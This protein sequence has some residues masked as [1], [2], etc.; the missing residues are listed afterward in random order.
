MIDIEMIKSGLL[1]KRNV[2]RNNDK[3]MK[4][5]QLLRWIVQMN[6]YQ[7]NNVIF[8]QKV[9]ITSVLHFYIRQIR[10]MTVANVSFQDLIT[11]GI[12]NFYFQRKEIAFCKY[13]Y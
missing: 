8:V 5:H 10:F 3:I 9:I 2:H 7:P 11:T 1:I 6:G 4:S 12:K 13:L